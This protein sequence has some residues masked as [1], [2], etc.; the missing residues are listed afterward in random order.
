MQ[1]EKYKIPINMHACKDGRQT[2]TSTDA[3]TH[4]QT[5]TH[6]RLKHTHKD[7]VGTK[8]AGLQ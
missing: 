2:H 5:H 3:R 8:A 6:T 4:W 1:A 7:A